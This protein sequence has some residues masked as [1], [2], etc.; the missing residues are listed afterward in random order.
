[1]NRNVNTQ[2]SWSWIA[3]LTTAVAVL[4]LMAAPM[5]LLAGHH[6]GPR[7]QSEDRRQKDIVD[8]AVANE[9]FSTLVAA[10]QAADLVEALKGDGPFTVF[11][12][13][14]E[15]FEALPEGTLD[16]L[17]DPEN[18]QALQAI[19]LYHVVPGRYP[20]QRIVNAQPTLRTLQGGELKASVEEGSV[21][22]NDATVIATD[23][24]STN[25]VI[26]VID[27]V[28]LPSVGEE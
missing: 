28:L 26:H 23:V 27:T 20:S 6:K 21:K 14:N 4:A 5:L 19:L 1:M 15:A 7:G 25:G 2:R 11:A 22:I 16:F 8:T 12:P 9:S 24:R 17:L 3:P 13:T 18:K 10:L